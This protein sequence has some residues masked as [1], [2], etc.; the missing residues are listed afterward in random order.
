[1]ESFQLNTLNDT[2]EFINKSIYL[3]CNLSISELEI[4]KEGA[5]YHACSYKLNNNICF[6]RLAKITPKKTGQFVTFWKRNTKGITEPYHANDNFD[7]LIIN[8]KFKKRFGQF[9]FPKI[10][11]IEK[12]IVSSETKNGKR[13]FRVYPEWDMTENNQA[14]KTQKWQLKYFTETNHSSKPSTI[15]ALIFNK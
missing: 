3:K 8:V 1:M 4:E 15:N 9:I 6:N 7:F 14:I 2:L 12:G 11:L 13:G 5:L 10:I